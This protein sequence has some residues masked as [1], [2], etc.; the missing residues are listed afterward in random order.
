[1]I[2]KAYLIILISL[3]AMTI[4]IYSPAIYH[5]ICYIFSKKKFQQELQTLENGELY[6]QC[7]MVITEPI[8]LGTEPAGQ[9]SFAEAHK[10]QEFAMNSIM[11]IMVGE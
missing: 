2:E 6:D 1:M 10:N 11:K 5:Y 3:I 8:G 4:A 9:I 7:R